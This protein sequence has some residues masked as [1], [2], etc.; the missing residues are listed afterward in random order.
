[1]N[2]KFGLKDPMFDEKE[3]EYVCPLEQSMVKAVRINH[4]AKPIVIVDMKFEN[5]GMK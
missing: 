4:P 2:K 3:W 1:M 5:D